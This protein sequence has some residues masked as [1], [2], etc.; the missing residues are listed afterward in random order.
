MERFITVFDS[1]DKANEER[2]SVVWDCV[3]GSVRVLPDGEWLDR[4]V[5]KSKYFEEATEEFANTSEIGPVYQDCQR[6]YQFPSR[7]RMGQEVL[8]I[9]EDMSKNGIKSIIPA[10]IKEVIF[11]DRKVKYSLYFEKSR[12]TIYNVDSIY[13]KK[14]NNNKFIEFE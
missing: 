13:V 9:L 3:S 1:G 2:Q 11:T 4:E 7:F 14:S 5:M 8:F 6:S 12:T 10:Y